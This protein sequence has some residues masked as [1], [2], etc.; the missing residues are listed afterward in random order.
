MLDKKK[1]HPKE[2]TR[3]HVR[4]KHRERY[5]LKALIES[6]PELAEHV[7]LNIYNDESINFFNP[8]AVKALNKALLKHHYQIDN[9]NIPPNYLCPPIPGRADYIH[10]IADLLCSSNYGKIPK[11]NLV[12]CHDIGVGANCVYPI[13]GHQEY[14]WNFIGSDIDQEAITSA[15]S[16]VESNPAL[17]GH[18]DICLQP[19]SN[20]FFNGII[21][22]D[23]YIDVAICNPPFHSSQAEAQSGTLRKLSNLSNKKVT[24][25]TLNFGGQST[26]LYCNGG[27]ARFVNDMI[28][29]SKQFATSC[30]WFSTLISKQSNLKRT[31]ATLKQVGASDVKTMPM[32]QGNKSSRIVAWTFLTKEEQKTWVNSKWNKIV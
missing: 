3:L 17:V 2:K 24:T 6:L 30:F 1:E 10:Y 12:T 5:N 26:E 32:G 16:I 7:S 15:K 28:F 20:H 9:W 22:E 23:E 18:V 11:G 27:E 19:S 13:I 4:N 21:Q 14:G 29:E 8:E 25:P 31:Y